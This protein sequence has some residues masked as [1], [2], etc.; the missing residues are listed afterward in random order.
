[1]LARHPCRHF[2]PICSPFC[3]VS[4]AAVSGEAACSPLRRCPCRGRA[5]LCPAGCASLKGQRGILHLILFPR[6]HQFHPRRSTTRHSRHVAF[7]PRRRRGCSVPSTPLRSCAALRAVPPPGAAAAQKAVC[8]RF[9][10][11]AAG[12]EYEKLSLPS[13]PPASLSVSGRGIGLGRHPVDECQPDVLMRTHIP[14]AIC[15][16]CVCCAQYAA[17]LHHSAGVLC[18][19]PAGGQGIRAAHGRRPAG[20][21]L[22]VLFRCAGKAPGAALLFFPIGTAGC[23]HLPCVPSGQADLGASNVRTGA[24]LRAGKRPAALFPY[25]TLLSPALHPFIAMARG[26]P[27]LRRPTG[28]SPSA[29]T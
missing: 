13:R 27:D 12:H 25:S 4:V 18:R 11:P 23:R 2:V 7:P 21:L 24:A 19:R 9:T 29:V 16:A 28:L 14:I 17:V 26:P 1:M 3:R 10:I 22:C 5:L 8:G 15:G 6:R 20:S